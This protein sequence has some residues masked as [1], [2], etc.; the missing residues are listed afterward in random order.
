MFAIRKCVQ[1]AT[2]TRFRGNRTSKVQEAARTVDVVPGLQQNSLCCIN[3]FTDTNYITIFIPYEVK[4]FNENKTTLT[5][6][7]KSILQWWRDPVCGLWC[8]PFHLMVT[9]PTPQNQQCTNNR[10]EAIIAAQPT[11]QN[12]VRVIST[13]QHKAN[14]KV[15]PCSGRIFSQNNL[16]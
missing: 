15:L 12:T 11:Q 14:C 3:K 1:H 4:I 6:I 7:D 13:A 5:S 10:T 9:N 2:G 8:I 16:A